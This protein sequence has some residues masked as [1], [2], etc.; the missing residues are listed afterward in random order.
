MQRV[1]MPKLNGKRLFVKGFRIGQAPGTVKL[2]TFGDEIANYRHVM[3]LASI[4]LKFN[5][6][7]AG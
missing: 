6:L 2:K 5:S 3:S 1:R 4:S 7:F